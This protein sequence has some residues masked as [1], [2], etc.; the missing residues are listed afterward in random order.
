MSVILAEAISPNPARFQAVFRL[1]S[2]SEVCRARSP[3]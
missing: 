1:K 3:E 2:F